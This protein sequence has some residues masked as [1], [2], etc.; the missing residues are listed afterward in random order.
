M[1]APIALEWLRQ[2]PA[3]DPVRYTVLRLAEDVAYGSG[4][5]AASARARSAAPLLPDVRFPESFPAAAERARKAA[6]RWIAAVRPAGRDPRSRLP[7]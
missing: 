2:R 5:T 4:V 7:R 6:G 3:V 1:L